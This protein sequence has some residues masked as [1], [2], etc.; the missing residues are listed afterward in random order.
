MEVKKATRKKFNLIASTGNKPFELDKT[1]DQKEIKAILKF[2]ESER[3]EDVSPNDFMEKET[4]GSGNYGVV[5]KMIHVKSGRLIAVKK[6]RSAAGDKHLRDL[7]VMDKIEFAQKSGLFCEF[8]V[9][10]YGSLFHEGECWLCMELMDTDCCTFYRA[11]YRKNNDETC[12]NQFIPESVIAEIA[13]CVVKALNFLKTTIKVMHR[14]VKPANILL[15]RNGKI[16]IADFGIAGRLVDSL[17]ATQSVGCNYYMAPEQIDPAIMQERGSTYDA[18]ADVWALGLTLFELATG[19]YPYPTMKTDI[20]LIDH[21]L[22]NPA[23]QLI[24]IPGQRSELITDFIN[25]WLVIFYFNT[26]LCLH[27]FIL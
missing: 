9:E 27:S 2:S 8:I 6:I 17:A 26:A 11:V 25:R 19:S 18:R 21:I 12:E 7:H 22:S 23:P 20:L 16:K 15:S 5:S 10:I 24:P 4:L 1:Q 14:D 3:Y 13:S